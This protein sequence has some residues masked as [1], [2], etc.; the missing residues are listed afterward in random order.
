MDGWLAGSMD[1]WIDWSIRV[2]GVFARCCFVTL[3]LWCVVVVCN[4]VEHSAY[5]AFLVSF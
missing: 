5:G 1:G 3:A 4:G 2:F